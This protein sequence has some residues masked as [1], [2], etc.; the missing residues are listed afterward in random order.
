M[1][2]RLTG[3]AVGGNPVSRVPEAGV[4]R[5]TIGTTSKSKVGSTGIVGHSLSPV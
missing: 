1:A 4:S 5:R 2:G 3:I